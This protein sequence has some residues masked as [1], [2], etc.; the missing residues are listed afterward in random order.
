M[1]PCKDCICLA[2]CKN[3]TYYRLI[4]DCSLIYDILYRGFISLNETTEYKILIYADLNPTS[5]FPTYSKMDDYYR[6]EI[7]DD[8]L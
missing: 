3:K 2:I 1:T 5:W 4:E 7:E 8:T 6:K